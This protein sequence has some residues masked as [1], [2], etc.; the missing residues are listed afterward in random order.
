MRWMLT[1]VVIAVV[2]WEK[3]EERCLVLYQPTLLW[4][5]IVDW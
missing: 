1:V 2:V 5:I 4:D 3:G